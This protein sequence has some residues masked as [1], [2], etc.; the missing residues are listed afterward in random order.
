MR[1][2]IRIGRCARRDQQ[3]KPQ[4]QIGVARM[5]RAH[6]C[7]R[8]TGAVSAHRQSGVVEPQLVALGC[9]PVHGCPAVCDGD[10][11]T[12]LRRKAVFQGDHCR[13]AAQCQLPA[14][15]VV[16]LEVANREAAAMQIQQDRQWP[17][18][19]RVE[20]GDQRCAILRRY[21]KIFDAGQGGTRQLQHF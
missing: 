9:E 19:G 5:N 13:T 7:Q 17:L 18:R 4:T 10:G 1:F 3:L 12:V 6:C 20:T 16:R 14:Q 8:G 21:L 11:K 2:A 15:A